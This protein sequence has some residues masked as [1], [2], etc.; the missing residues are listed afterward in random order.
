MSDMGV[1][2]E[3]PPFR[4]K[5]SWAIMELISRSGYRFQTEGSKAYIDSFI[6]AN[7]RPTLEEVRRRIELLKQE[8]EESRIRM[9]MKRNKEKRRG[10]RKTADV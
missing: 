2:F 6:L 9:R 3:P 10:Y 1:Y 7:E 4:A 8:K 5:K